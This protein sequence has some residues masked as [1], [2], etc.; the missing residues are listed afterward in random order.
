MTNALQQI[1]VLK[2][3]V[4]GLDKLVPTAG[5]SHS[6]DPLADDGDKRPL[7]N[8]NS[9]TTAQ[10]RHVQGAMELLERHQHEAREAPMPPLPDSIE[11]LWNP[12]FPTEPV[13]PEDSEIPPR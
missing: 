8:L 12:D 5:G 9:L 3:K 11:D 6:S 10:L 13:E 4:V 2:C 1:V 7:V